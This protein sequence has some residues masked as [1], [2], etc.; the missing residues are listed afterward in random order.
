MVKPFWR[1]IFH[2]IVFFIIGRLNPNQQLGQNAYCTL[3]DVLAL[4]IWLYL[5]KEDRKLRNLNCFLLTKTTY[6]LVESFLAL[7]NPFR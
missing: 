2:E 5:N 6:Y 3:H 4:L 1:S 7:K